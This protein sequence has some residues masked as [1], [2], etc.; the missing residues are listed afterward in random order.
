VS[1]STSS[2]VWPWPGRDQAGGE[3]GTPVLPGQSEFV[4]TVTIVFELP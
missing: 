4:V 2:P 3:G 1:E